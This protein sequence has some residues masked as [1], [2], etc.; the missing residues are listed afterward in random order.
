MADRGDARG[1]VPTV[2]LGDISLVET[3]SRDIP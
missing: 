1:T 3:V 2:G